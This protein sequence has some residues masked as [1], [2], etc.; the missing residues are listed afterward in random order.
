[1][2]TNRAPGRSPL[3]QGPAGRTLLALGIA[4]LAVLS[5]I[6][7]VRRSPE[8][9]AMGVFVV[10]NAVAVLT[11]ASASRARQMEETVGEAQEEDPFLPPTLSAQQLDAAQAQALLMRAERLG[12]STRSRAIVAPSLFLL[13]LGCLCSMS[14]VALHLASLADERLIWLP[15]AVSMLWMVVLLIAFGVFQRSTRA[16]FAARWIQVM[17]T[18]G[19]LWLLIILG[20]TML[21]RGELWFTLAGIGAITLVTTWGAWREARQ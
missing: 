14:L 20:M 17:T 5:V 12:A 9:A 7:V 18:W 16:G 15:L 6:S 11:A 10:A 21:W 13:A 4:A 19:V 2:S 1:M 8:L 3:L